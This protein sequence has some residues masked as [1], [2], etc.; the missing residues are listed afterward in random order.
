MGL[1]RTQLTAA[2]AAAGALAGG[3]VD[4]A[5]AAVSFPLGTLVGGA[6]G[7]AASWYAATK[8]PEVKIHGFPLGGQLLKIGPMQN[9]GFPWVVLDRALLY[10][11]AVA[12]RP[13]AV[14]G[15]IRLEADDAGRG[16]VGGLDATTRKTVE[17]CLAGL[18]RQPNPE[19]RDQICRDLGE[20]IH[21]ILQ[22]RHP[23]DT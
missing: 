18:R 23:P 7:G 19:T 22:I 20:Q 2:G 5:S 14:R 13:H 8:L 1:S 15:Q 3:M 11:D 9:P 6:T 21:H 12:D 10:V 17:G 4:V 16:I